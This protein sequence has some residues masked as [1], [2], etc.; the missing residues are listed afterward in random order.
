MS[1]DCWKM[2]Q[3]KCIVRREDATLITTILIS[4]NLGST[5]ICPTY[6]HNMPFFSTKTSFSKPL[7]CSVAGPCIIRN[8]VW[9]K[10]TK[11]FRLSDTKRI[12]II[13]DI[14]IANLHPFLR[15]YSHSVATIF[16]FGLLQ[17]FDI[18]FSKPIGIWNWN[19]YPIYWKWILCVVCPF[20][21]RS[22]TGIKL[23][24]A[25]YVS[26]NSLID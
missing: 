22:N 25:R 26:A 14:V 16:P 21:P 24:T 9:K 20:F 15:Y 1:D 13:I 18:V 2:N 19:L 23:R 10:I 11:K 5:A 8:M 6:P 7:A 4:S 3:S 12:D 17:I